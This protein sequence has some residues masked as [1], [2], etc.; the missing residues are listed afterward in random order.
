M[1]ITKDQ[2]L[3][4]LQHIL[5]YVIGFFVGKHVFDSAAGAEL[6]AA[7]LFFI[8]FGIQCY[9]NRKIGTWFNVD[10]FTGG[11]QHLFTFLVAIGVGKGWFSQTD[12]A[13]LAGTA[14]TLATFLVQH[15]WEST[16]APTATASGTAA[17]LLIVA[18]VSG[19]VLGS[20]NGCATITGTTDP[21]QQLVVISS[22][23]TDGVRLAAVAEINHD[24]NSRQYFVLASE[25]LNTL[26]ANGTPTLTQINAEIAKVVPAQ[27]QDIISSVTQIAADKYAQWYAVNSTKLTSDQTAQD[28]LAIIKAARDGLN[29]AVA[30]TAPPATSGAAVPSL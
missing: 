25:S 15:Q 21:A 9:W 16:T 27:Y 18:L 2:L 13:S 10:Q 19:A 5:T 26:T 12:G 1:K 28:A 3:G 22:D 20:L 4:A 29:E 11:L 8:P 23:V 7:L 6:T 17:N 30:A 24:A 14:L